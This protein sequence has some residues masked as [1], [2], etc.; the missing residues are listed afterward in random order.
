MP[1]HE[2]QGRRGVR[3]LCLGSDELRLL[4][5]AEGLLRR[6]ARPCLHADRRLLYIRREEAH[7]H[8]R[9][10]EEVLPSRGRGKG[11]GG[12][13]GPRE[14]QDRLGP[15]PGRGRGR[16]KEEEEMSPLRFHAAYKSARRL[17]EIA[18]V[19]VR[20][21]FFPLMERMHLTRLV[22]IPLRLAGRRFTKEA[23]A[24]TEPER[25][26]LALE[27]LGPTFIK[28]GQIL[29]T[30]PDVVPHEF[31]IEFLKLHDSVTPFPFKDAVKVIEAQFGR[32]VS[33][34]FSSIEETPV[35]AASIAQ[36]HR[37]VTRG[38]QEVMVKVQRPGIEQT[39]DTDIAILGY[40][41]RLVEK[42]MPESR[43]YDPSGM[44]EEFSAVIHREMDF[45]LEA[46]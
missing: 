7:A 36:V 27:E 45:T 30:R 17:R 19:L 26:R 20:H 25:A 4:R 31:I 41:A 39:V 35:A 13:S 2:G 28:F 11:K 24:L 37:A 40:I 46:R 23:E 34:L 10:D 8:R 1:V 42:Y 32:P 22:S 5:G 16:E 44:V 43:L 3:R 15:C 6:G 29:S 38:G 21:G 33:E 9:E 14:A 18:T 12:G